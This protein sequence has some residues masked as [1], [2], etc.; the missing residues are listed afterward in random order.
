[1]SICLID[2]SILCEFLGVPN[3]SES[4]A[5]IAAEMSA[6]IERRESLLLPMS[7]ILETG[8]HIGKN[9][10][11]RQ[12]RS[13]AQRFVLLVQQAIRGETPFTPTPF[14]ETEALLLWIEE[15]PG[16]A[17]RTDTLASDLFR[18]RN[19][20]FVPRNQDVESRN[21]HVASRNQDFEPRN[22]DLPTRNQHVRSRYADVRRRHAH[23]FPRHAHIFPRHAH[24]FP[25]HAHIS[26]R[27]ARIFPG[28]H[29]LSIG[30]EHFATQHQ[31]FST[32][33]QH[34]RSQIAR[35]GTSPPLIFP[36]LHP[37]GSLF[38]LSA[39]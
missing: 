24:I 18:S 29:D 30:N 33:D 25:R 8:N 10:D 3:L 9:G 11:G 16:W 34:L 7:T 2:T 28:N 35:P 13:T 19:Q 17:M 5:E 32:L 36:S 38:Q 6:K 20:H 31:H 12:R 26:P 39:P 4:S 15:F 21:Q 23:I 1:V 22:H 27:Y 37:G 14:F